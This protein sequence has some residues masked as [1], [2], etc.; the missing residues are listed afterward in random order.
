MKD[1]V[2]FFRDKYKILIPVMVGVVLLITMFFLYREYQYDNKRNKNNESVFQ[3]FAGIRTDYTAE[4]TYN[5]RDAIVDLR[6]VDAKIEY[7]S[8]PIYYS[9]LEKVIFPHDMNIVFPLRDGGQFRLYKYA[10]YYNLD[11]VHFIKNNTD[12]GSY[13]DFFLYDGDNLYFF[14]DKVMLKINDKDYIELGPMSYVN[15]V[16]GLTLVYYDTT[17]DSGDMIELD[18]DKVS[19]SSE[20]ININITDRYFKVFNRN[21]LLMRPNNLNPVFKTIDK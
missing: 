17:T 3:Y 15:V 4:I 20:Y 11:D 12:T 6:A 7:D 1:I 14:P 2:K 21:V 13:N 19:I 16:G 9:N 5:L 18:G 8:T 10:T